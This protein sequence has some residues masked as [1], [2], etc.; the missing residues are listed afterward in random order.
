MSIRSV[1][2]LYVKTTSLF[3][4]AIMIS[5][6]AYAYSAANFMGYAQA[7]RLYKDGFDGVRYSVKA[8]FFDIREVWIRF[9]LSIKNTADHEPENALCSLR[10]NLQHTPSN[11]H[12]RY[13]DGVLY[14]YF[15]TIKAYTLLDF[16]ISWDKPIIGGTFPIDAIVSIESH[17]WSKTTTRKFNKYPESINTYPVQILIDGPERCHLL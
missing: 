1:N 11:D 17:E 13:Q 4:L 12:T 14:L 8:P 10:L 7:N 16:I 2:Y 5:N 6:V 9:D 3:L 15:D